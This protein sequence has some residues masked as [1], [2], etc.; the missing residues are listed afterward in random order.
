MWSRIPLK[1]WRK[2]SIFS[3]VFCSVWFNA[4]TAFL[5]LGFLVGNTAAFFIFRALWKTFF[6]EGLSSTFFVLSICLPPYLACASPFTTAWTL[7]LQRCLLPHPLLLWIPSPISSSLPPL[8]L[9][10][11]AA[12][13]V[14][15]SEPL[16]QTSVGQLRCPASSQGCRA[17]RLVLCAVPGPPAAWARFPGEARCRNRRPG[18][19]N[20]SP[21]SCKR[22][23]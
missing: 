12:S 7:L 2:T 22:H 11:D 18:M 19:W 4:F 6:R 13:E 8:Q 17:S 15:L 9:R 23:W 20:R 1:H 21:L 5:W 14:P 16:L 10:I 3:P